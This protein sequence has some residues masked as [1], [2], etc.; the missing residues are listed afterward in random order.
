[1]FEF[2]VIVVVIVVAVVV[3]FLIG[4]QTRQKFYANREILA[5]ALNQI[6]AKSSRMS[7]VPYVSRGFSFNSIC[8][9]KSLGLCIYIYI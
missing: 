8:L 5:T 4:L 9:G 3:N 1:M 6:G 2:L 7:Q